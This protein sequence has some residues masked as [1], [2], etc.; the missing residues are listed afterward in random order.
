MSDFAPGKVTDG[1][2]TL[3]DANQSTAQTPV[4]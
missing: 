3:R 2:L 1:T 4:T